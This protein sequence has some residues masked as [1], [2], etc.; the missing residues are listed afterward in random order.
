[1]LK[2]FENSRKL[3]FLH[4]LMQTDSGSSTSLIIMSF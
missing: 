4:Y 3:L 1:M 2:I